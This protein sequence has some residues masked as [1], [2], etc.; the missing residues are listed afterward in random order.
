MVNFVLQPRAFTSRQDLWV[1]MMI[2]IIK[3]LAMIVAI[4]FTPVSRSVVQSKF[5]TS[6]DLRLA[7]VFHSM[8][9]GILILST[10]TMIIVQT[11]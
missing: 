5:Q 1:I 3:L 4:H 7:S 9:I 10:F 11:I 6:I 8:L 2:I